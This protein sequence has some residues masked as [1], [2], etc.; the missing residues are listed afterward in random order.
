MYL[1]VILI[2]SYDRMFKNNIDE[3]QL[4]IY[5]RSYFSIKLLLRFVSR[6]IGGFMFLI[7]FLGT[8][9]CYRLLMTDELLLDIL[10]F[11]VVAKT[12]K[13]ITHDT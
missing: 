8:Y 7:P 12:P 9:H 2:I 1:L 4:L 11:R 10:G 13:T 5:K 6:Y 3:L